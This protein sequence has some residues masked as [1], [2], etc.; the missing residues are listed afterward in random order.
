MN[1]YSLDAYGLLEGTDKTTLVQ[2]YL[3]HYERIFAG[4]RNE[5]IQ[6]LEIGVAGGASLR[7]WARF[8]PEA[9]IVGIDINP[10]CRAYGGDRI[11]IEIGS[12]AN[13]EFLASLVMKY[14]PDIVVDDGSHL[15]E[16]ILMTFHQLIPFLR[17]GGYY[18]IEDVHLHYGDH[19]RQWHKTG[20]TTPSA[21]FAGISEM[22]SSNHIGSGCD[23]M[24]R[25]LAGC[26]DTIEFVRGAIIARKKPEQD[27]E[28]QLVYWRD[29]AERS[30]KSYNWSELSRVL[31]Q[32][33][34]LEAAEAAIRRALAME[35]D[36]PRYLSRLAHTL[37]RRGDKARAIE[38]MRHVVQLVP[39]DPAPRE[40]LAHFEALGEA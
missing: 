40:L 12:Q 23:T 15:A 3:R 6:L 24:T 27:A 14:Q 36:S 33:C 9:W 26:L 20:G 10:G 28:K 21:Y 4:I 17:P 32:S 35:P 37:V 1:D 19:A 38:T 7:T 31:L 13:P 16:D 25:Y 8:F 30:G 18:V 29:M 11:T 22:L 2:D 39:H 5:P 34:N